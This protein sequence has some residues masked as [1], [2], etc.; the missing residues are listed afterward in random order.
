MK[1]I[2]TTTIKEAA[3]RWTIQC[4]GSKCTSKPAGQSLQSSNFHAPGDEPVKWCLQIC[5]NGLYAGEEGHV[6]IALYPLSEFPMGCKA[7]ISFSLLDEDNKLVLWSMEISSY[8]KPNDVRYLGVGRN[9]PQ[10][11]FL[12]VDKLV[13]Y[14]KL[15]YEVEKLQSLDP[16]S[17]ISSAK[18][19]G[20][21]FEKLFTS[22]SNSDITFKIGNKEFPAH[23]AIITFRSPVFAAMFKQETSQNH[24]DITGIEL[25]IFQSVLRFIYTDQ[26]DLTAGNVLPLLA[27]ANQYSLDLLKEKCGEFLSHHLSIQ[28]CC[29]LLIMADTHG[30]LSLKTAAMDYICKMSSEVTR[31]E[32]WKKM[33]NQSRPEL[34]YEIVEKLAQLV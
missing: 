34:A 33:R 5:P 25:D 30:I 19:I 2:T 15:K 12:A 24:V 32:G 17:A 18:S 28:N 31:S 21:D 6:N 27:A 4:F 8:F 3:I 20:A 29:E 7:N 22:M 23:K 10:S 11:K 16:P 14:C 9:I 1:C 26:V 13:V